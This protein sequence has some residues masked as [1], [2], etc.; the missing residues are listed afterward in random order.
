MI[1]GCLGERGAMV[2]DRG[3]GVRAGPTGQPGP[4]G[5]HWRPAIVS[6]GSLILRGA[7]SRPIYAYDSAVVG[8]SY[9]SSAQR[10]LMAPLCVIHAGA[11]SVKSRVAGSDGC[12]AGVVKG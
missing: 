5:Q 10:A 4:T 2:T 8:R 6:R 12:P 7:R 9:G 11:G 3:P 1:A